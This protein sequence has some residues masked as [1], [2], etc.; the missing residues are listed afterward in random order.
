MEIDN[1]NIILI[2]AHTIKKDVYFFMERKQNLYSDDNVTKYDEF[3]CTE[4][5]WLPIKKQKEN[6]KRLEKIT[7]ED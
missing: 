2:N 7:D 6:A 4:F 1:N 3:V 5:V